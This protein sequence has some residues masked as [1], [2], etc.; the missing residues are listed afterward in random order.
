MVPR[1]VDCF[2]KS[3]W[4]SWW[5]SINQP[6]P[7]PQIWFINIISMELVGFL[8][9]IHMIT[10]IY[11]LYIQLIMH[12]SLTTAKLNEE[13]IIVT[14][15]CL[16]KIIEQDVFSHWF[17]KW[18]CMTLASINKCQTERKSLVRW[19]DRPLCSKIVNYRL[20]KESR[21]LNHELFR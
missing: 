2:L 7:I 5:K 18:E 20:N 19:R 15:L 17:V 12:V 14:R 9:E 3:I 16:N 8:S 1:W 6:E 4:S 21:G 10:H 13:L 11:A